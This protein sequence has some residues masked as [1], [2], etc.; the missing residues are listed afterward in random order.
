MSIPLK[1]GIQVM[2]KGPLHY[3]LDDE[4]RPNRYQPW[5]G[6]AFAF[7]YDY[8]MTRS[9]FPKKFNASLEHHTAIL[10]DAC[11]AFHGKR[12]L[13]LGTGAGS[14]AGFLP[15]DN[16]YVGSDVSTGLLKQAVKRFNQA[17]FQNPE[18]YI[19]SGDDLPFAGETFDLCL[20]ILSLNFIG[21][22]RQVFKEAHRLLTDQGEFLCC[23][24]VPERNHQESTIRGRLLSE[25]RLQKI[26]QETAFSLEPLKRENGALTYFRAVKSF[27]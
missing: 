21:N 20:C 9:V 16:T 18:F 27:N 7:L 22:H 25:V 17:G 3:Q 19:A 13:E 2:Q 5:L 4:G 12:I 14:A 24:P 1:P 23:V 10:A 26:C 11:Q 8:F 6:D 15:P